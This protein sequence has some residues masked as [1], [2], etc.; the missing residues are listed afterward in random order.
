MG[1][2]VPETGQPGFSLIPP[3][4]SGIWFSNSIPESIHLTNQILLDGSG[5]AA[6]DVDGDGRCDLYFCAINGRNTL[7]RNMGEWHFEDITEKAG[8]GCEGLRSTGAALADLNGDGS[9][10][11]IVNTTG[12]GTRIFFNDGHGRFT[13]APAILNPG[14]GGRSLAIGD[15]DG[16][17]YPDIYVVNYRSSAVMDMPNSR[18]TFK[19]VQGK[20][21]VDTFNG[22]PVTD[23][24]LVDRF[25]VGPNGDFQENGEPDVLYHN[26]GGTNFVPIPFSGGNFL[27]EEGRPL[28]KAP[29]DWGLSAMF[30]D[31]N[32]DGL[33]DLY[34]CNDFQSP[35]RFWLNQGGGK[36]RLLPLKAQRKSS[37]SSMA[38]DFA[39]INRD[40]FDDFLVL[41]MMSRAHSER[42]R[43]MSML[44]DQN[45]AAGQSPDRPQYELN[46]L[47]LNRGDNTYAEIGQLS[48]V[49]AAEWAWSGIFLDVDLDGWEDLLVVNGMERTGR[50][51]DSTEYIRRL[52]AS[53]QGSDVQIFRARRLSPR[54]VNGNLAFRNRRDL[55]FQEISEPWGFHYKGLS[56]AMAL[57]D[58]NNDGAL[59]VVINP[60][61]APPLIYRNLSAAP[62]IAVRLKGLAPNTRGIGSRIGVIGGPVAVQTQEMISGGRY[63]SC[64]DAVRTFAAGTLTNQLTIEV[65]WRSGRRS[66]VTNAMPNRL[67]EIDEA[68]AQITQPGAPRLP[69]CRSRLAT[70]QPARASPAP[71][72]EDVSEKL[73]HVH[74]DEPF[75]DFSR[76]PL[77]PNKLSQLGPGLAWFDVDRDGAEDLIIGGGSG[78]RL[79]IYRND[80]QGGFSP[81]KENFY[82]AALNRDQTAVLAW[83]S[84]SNGPVILAGSA[85]YEDGQVTGPAVLEYD[86]THKTPTQAVAAN[87]SST[88]PIAL[89][90]LAG[91][92]PLA[93]F[94]GG[95]VI[96]G[97]WPEA[98][99]SRIFRRDGLE[100]K[101]DAENSRLLDRIGL[102][103]GA[104][105]GDLDGDGFPE[106]ILACEWGSIRIF[107]NDRGHL[108][109]TNFPIRAASS[110]GSL[111][112]PPATLNELTGWWNSVTVGDFDGDGR[113]DLV[114]GNWGR[115][116]KYQ[117]QRSGSILVYYGD[118]AGDG[119]VQILEAHYEPP[120]QKTVP[121][122]QRDALAR[123]IPAVRARFSSHRAYS[124]A[125]V[126]EVLGPQFA[127]ARV[128][129]AACLESV[130]LLN[131]GD[132]FELHELPLEAQ[133]SPAFGLCVGDLDGDGHEDLFVA[134]NFFEAQPETPRYDAG[135]GLLLL[136]DGQGQFRAMPGQESGIKIYGEQRGAALCDFD[137]DGR[138]DLAVAQN[139]AETCLLHNT[140]AKP[141]LR[142]R[143]EGP[144][145]NPDAFGAVMRLKFGGHWGAARELHG[146]AGYWS[147]DGT[148]QVLATPTTPDQLQVRWPGGKTTTSS[149]P[150]GAREIRV[151]PDGGL[152][153]TR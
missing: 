40:G 147:Q 23:P 11:L 91:E 92:G 59:D 108:V 2:A 72:F 36:F 45:M 115:N 112:N 132:H 114:A 125:S 129:Q 43:F 46:T 149:I 88:G 80:G 44:S 123:G 120:L 12:N 57:A 140:A 119:S 77:L 62:R 69:S 146:G 113:L 58:L 16:D 133:M 128:L 134:Q 139:N 60:L 32:G 7:Y 13:P 96:G 63:L 107:H 102:V 101:L 93:L 27:D 143:L 47:F 104:V 109:E 18:A 21:V 86:L 116:T 64:D 50:D 144:A 141:G 106:L 110:S 95:R 117:A 55:T 99:S 142:V 151:A 83:H 100:W 34:V 38:V 42:M 15:V 103:S 137:G 148:V 37:M 52:R 78:G 30:R 29:L 150:S 81:S 33:P 17:G 4:T 51:L 152:T 70:H 35:D 118:L 9:L 8:V 90:A 74:R 39:D 49:E 1:L 135:R 19:M 138:V 87:Q 56:S 6:G 25:T 124:V 79:A 136:G 89:G 130:V 5:V 97:R 65:A 85:N 22:R 20:L 31:V 105:F 10:D 66:L 68:A 145:N 26:L 71:L 122:R 54:Q 121:L 94:V 48:G 14:R 76:Q 28:A 98:A 3:S 127:H 126:R 41:D 24:D 73:G 82:A 84:T 53:G 67:Y 153:A 61:N 111:K 131:R 75:D